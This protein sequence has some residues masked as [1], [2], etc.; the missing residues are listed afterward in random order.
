MNI[1]V[2]N[3]ADGGCALRKSCHGDPAETGTTPWGPL[4]GFEH[5]PVEFTPFLTAILGQ[6]T[7]I[8]LPALMAL[9]PLLDPVNIGME[10]RV[11]RSDQ[12][13]RLALH[14]ASK[15]AEFNGGVRGG[16]PLEILDA[17]DQ[18]PEWPAV[19]HALDHEQLAF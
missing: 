9:Q 15:E 13:P 5:I 11:D 19:G 16:M 17:F 6:L 1:P 12:E 7:Y 18:G 14:T 10:Q 4:T 8:L 3:H 2:C